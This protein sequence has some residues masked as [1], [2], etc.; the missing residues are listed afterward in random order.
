[1]SRFLAGNLQSCF[2]CYFNLMFNGRMEETNGRDE[3]RTDDNDD[4]SW[5]EAA[6]RATRN[7][8]PVR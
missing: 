2:Y 5:G 7:P 6:R 4:N 3:R 1:M 8:P